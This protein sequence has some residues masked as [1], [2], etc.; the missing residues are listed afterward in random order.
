M[1][2]GGA[3]DKE[4]YTPIIEVLNSGVS[5]G[6]GFSETVKSLRLFVEGGEVAGGTVVEGKLL[7]YV[8]QM[9]SDSFA[10]SDR[11]Y[12]NNVSAELGLEFYLY[13]GGLIEDSRD[14]CKA[15][16]GRYFH[17]KE[18]EQWVAGGGTSEGNPEPNVEWQ[19]QYRGTNSASIFSVCGGYNCKHTLMPVSTAA[20]PVDVLRR[21]LDAGNLVLNEKQ[22][23]ILGLA[24]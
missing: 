24:A 17:E 10:L 2:V 14:F 23:E 5:T 4:F 12:N 11:T 15:R 1:L 16:N 18:I 3:I 9:A 22:R 20:V 19:G 21:N 8:K 6:A 13:S 7:R